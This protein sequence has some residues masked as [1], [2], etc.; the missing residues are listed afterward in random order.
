MES[1]DTLAMFKDLGTPDKSLTILPN[2]FHLL[3]VERVG[4]VRLQES[5]FFGS[6]KNK[7]PREMGALATGLLQFFLDTP[8]SFLVS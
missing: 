6:Q 3:F 7:I 1:D 8:F 2:R 4:H 5:I